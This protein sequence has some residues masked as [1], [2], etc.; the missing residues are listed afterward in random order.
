M[1]RTYTVI[2]PGAVGTFLA[3]SLYR[4]GFPVTLA[5][6]K[7]ERSQRLS[8]NGIRLI[9]DSKEFTLSVPV[10]SGLETSPHSDTCVV[11]IKSYSNELF[12]QKNSEYLTR[13]SNIL[14]VQNGIAWID[15]Y[16]DSF[17]DCILLGGIAY[18][19]VTLLEEGS[20]RLAGTGPMRIGPVSP[21]RSTTHQDI[22]QDLNKAGIQTESADSIQK[23]AW[24]KL[25]V[26]L[27]I[28][29]L[30]VLYNCKNGE[31]LDSGE[32]EHTLETVVS[33]GVETA[34][35]CG[36]VFDEQDTIEAVKETCRL[37]AANVSSMLQDVRARKSTELEAITGAV[38]A[39]AQQ[40]GIDTPKNREVYT[41][42]A[43]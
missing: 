36:F 6:Y 25:L 11:C 21:G 13:F 22:A 19:G 30:T 4:A 34:G 28:N 17:D 8:Q 12:L 24:K 27:G 20:I 40:H 16:S 3:A 42:L 33:E 39:K 37:T 18:F 1:N 2:G 14:I 9:Q 35:A 23:E 38:L 7:S 10:Y 5:D 32:R 41:A 26:N 15:L 29:P 31:L 43:M